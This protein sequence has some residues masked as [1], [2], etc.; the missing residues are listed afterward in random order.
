MPELFTSDELRC[1]CQRSECDARDTVVPEMLDR[2]YRA[3]EV[4]NAPMIVTSG[5]RCAWWNAKE[6]IGGVISGG[7][8]V[9]GEAVDIQCVTSQEHY[10]MLRAAFAAGFRRLGIAKAFVHFG[11]S[12]TLTQDVQW[13]YPARGTA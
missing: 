13:L 11:V 10:F 12:T 2:L 7:E 9:A 4:Y 8:H 5:L 3:R 6:S 1:R